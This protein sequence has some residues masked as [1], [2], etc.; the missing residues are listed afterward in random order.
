MIEESGRVV[1]T[2]GEYAWIETGRATACGSCASRSGC[3]TSVLATLFGRRPANIRV[4]NSIGAAVGEQVVIGISES[5][6]VRGSLAV[7]LVPLAGLFAGAL[8]G[9]SLAAASVSAPGDLASMLGGAGGFAAG[10]VWLRR[11]SRV[12]A[13]NARYQPVMLRRQHMTP[14]TL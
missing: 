4:V 3:G 2:R 11:F 12:S 1:S 5:G 8:A 6:L 10:I 14:D 7:Y 13:R 9:Q